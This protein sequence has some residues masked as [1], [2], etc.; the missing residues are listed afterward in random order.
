MS[1]PRTV[2]ALDLSSTR[3]V[4]AVLRDGTLLF[5]AAFTAE[6]SHNAQVFPPLSQALDAIGAEPAL[7]V[8]GTGPG[9]YTG[10][11]I[12]IAAAQGIALS[13]GWP[14]IGWPS[15]ATAPV[16]TYHILGDARRGM[17]YTAAVTHHSLGPIQIID[18]ETALTLTTTG[19]PW[20]SFDSKVPLS[21]PQVTLVPPDA[22]A[23]ARIAAALPPQDIPPLTRLPLE[24]VY[25]QE[26]FITTPKKTGKKVPQA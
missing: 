15:I 10:V 24:P 7:I 3:G 18:A 19:G 8:I 2:L 14:L 13:R 25:L 16:D 22:H 4:I 9:S 6:R 21:L 23:L 26:A 11:R 12:A 5:E 20:Y 17:Y 1:H